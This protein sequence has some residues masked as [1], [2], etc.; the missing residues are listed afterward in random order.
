[1]DRNE[2]YC[3]GDLDGLCGLDA[4]INALCALCPEIDED[5]ASGLF[6]HLARHIQLQRL[7]EPMPII[8][9]GVGSTSLRLLLERALRFVRKNLEV[10]IELVEF[11][12][13]RRNFELRKLWRLMS[14]QLDGEHVVI[15]MTRGASHHW[16]VA[17]AATETTLRLIDS[18]ERKVLMRSRCTLKET[19]SRFRL[20]PGDMFFLR[21]TSPW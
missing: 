12:V 14:E 16:T 6:G 7:K 11:A 20:S 5:I 1:M 8:A 15:L 10:E 13:G 18:Y 3:Q 19:R 9:Y 21:R 2:P 17:Y 4:I